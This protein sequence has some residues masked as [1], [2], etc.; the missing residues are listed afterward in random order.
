M[1]LEVSSNLNYSIILNDKATWRTPQ[2]TPNLLVTCRRSALSPHAGRFP[3]QVK[4]SHLRTCMLLLTYYHTPFK[5][6]SAYCLFF[7][8]GWSQHSPHLT[9]QPIVYC[10][11]TALILAYCFSL[12]TRNFLPLLPWGS[13][14]VLHADK[15]VYLHHFSARLKTCCLRFAYG[16]QMAWMQMVSFGKSCREQQTDIIK[17][18]VSLPVETVLLQSLTYFC[19][20]FLTWMPGIFMTPKACGV[21]MLPHQHL[22]IVF[23]HTPAIFFFGSTCFFWQNFLRFSWEHVCV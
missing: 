20:G 13:Q 2:T 23:L 18:W 15:Y 8:Q 12:R 19:K 5:K 17:H 1:M 4:H 16:K 21:Q 11:V 6:R 14:Y 10:F 7:N 22:E 9:S 3:S